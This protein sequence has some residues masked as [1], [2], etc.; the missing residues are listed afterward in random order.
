MMSFNLNSIKRVILNLTDSKFRFE[1]FSTIYFLMLGF[2]YVYFNELY[3]LNYKGPSINIIKFVHT[4][5]LF[6]LLLKFIPK[7]IER[8]SDLFVSIIFFIILLPLLVIF[9]FDI[10]YEWFYIYSVLTTF[11]LLSYVRK[12]KLFNSLK[13]IYKKKINVILLIKILTLLGITFLFFDV[14]F[15]SF[16]LNPKLVYNFRDQD[17]SKLSSY[18]VTWLSKISIPLLACFAFIRKKYILMSCCILALIFLYGISSEKSIFLFPLLGIITSILFYKTKN[19]SLIP[20]FFFVLITIS[21][22]L[23]TFLGYRYLPSMI[24]RRGFFVPS[25]MIL[26]YIKFFDENQFTYWSQN[27]IGN[28]FSDYPYD[29]PPGELINKRVF[30]KDIGSSNCSFLGTAFMHAGFLGSIIYGLI[31]GIIL[32]FIDYFNFKNTNFL[33]ITSSSIV[34]IFTII[35][36]TDLPTGMLTH[37]LFISLMIIPFISEKDFFIKKTR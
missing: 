10:R 26:H 15:D 4:I 33:L 30:L 21:I 35:T 13:F 24:I 36:T 7:S 12:I 2:C 20:F 37:G 1:F 18:L 3:F 25:E 6:I 8:I 34:P 17:F 19:L 23:F 32:N 22:I 14:G 31:M 5:F 11:F 16:N 29:L 28:F 9:L 27:L